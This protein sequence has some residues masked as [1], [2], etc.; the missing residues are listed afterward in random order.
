MGQANYAWIAFAI[1]LGILSHF[2]RSVRWKMLMEPM[3]YKPSTSN[4]F[5]AVMIGYLAN[6]ALPRLG[7]VSRCG[8]LTRYEKI[9]FNKSFGTVIAERTVDMILFLLLF[10]ANLF[11]QSE[12]LYVYVQTRIYVPLEAK[13]NYTVD[14]TGYLT[15]AVIGLTLLFLVILLLL[16]KRIKRSSFFLKIKNLLLGFLEGIKSV[17]KVRNPFL[18]GFYS[19]AIWFLYLLMAYLVFFSLPATSRLGLDAGLAVL[20]FGSIGIM[21]V[22]GGIGIYPAIVAETLILYSITNTTGY[23]MGWLIW[24]S[25]TLTLIVMGVLSLILLPIFNKTVHATA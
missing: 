23:A 7:E 2:L 1:L 8:I 19:L 22:Q 5:F 25:Q 14:F 24:S 12:R 15:Y 3:G 6:L 10:F 11:I 21:L 4:V 9:P 20:I 13:F 16:W 18:F 17:Y